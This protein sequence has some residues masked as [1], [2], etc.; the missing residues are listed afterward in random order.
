MGFSEVSVDEAGS[1]GVLDP[2]DRMEKRP[3]DL[4]DSDDDGD[5]DD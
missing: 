2:I 4:L 3:D 5:L 1:A